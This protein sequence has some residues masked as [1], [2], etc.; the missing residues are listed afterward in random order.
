MPGSYGA[1]LLV[2]DHGQP[3]GR[4][5]QGD[6]GDQRG[7][8]V[9]V[10]VL[11]H[12]RPGVVGYAVVGVGEPGALLGERQRGLLGLGEHGGLAPRGDQVEPYRGFT[13]RRGL[14]GVHVDAPTAAVDLAGAQRHQFLGGLWQRRLVDHQVALA[15]RL[16]NLAPISLLIMSIRGSMTSSSLV[17]LRAARIV[18]AAT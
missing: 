4:V 14:L 9:V 8:L 17:E 1:T 2:H 15:N 13:G 6:Q 5:D 16:A 12:L 3:V 10:V 11:A 18:R 7:D